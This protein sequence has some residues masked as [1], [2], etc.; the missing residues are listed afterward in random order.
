MKTPRPVSD[1]PK[2]GNHVGDLIVLPSGQVYCWIE[3][4]RW[5]RNF[6]KERELK[7]TGGQKDE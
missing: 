3:F 4:K 6:S 1:F 2:V 7:T 5:Q